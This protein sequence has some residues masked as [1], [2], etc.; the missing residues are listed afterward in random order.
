MIW[1]TWRQHRGQILTT[2][3]FLLALGALLL[4]SGLQ[5]YRISESLRNC[6]DSAGDLCTVFVT[7]IDGLYQGVYQVYGWM[8]LLIPALIGAFWGAPLL[9]R[10]FERG[11]D[12]LVWTQSVP[13][14][15]WIVVKLA[16]LG[17]LVTLG[18]LALSAMASA[19]RVAFDA[20][21]GESWFGNIGVFN[22]V[23]VAPPAW[24]LFAFALGTASGALLR[25]VLP[26]M[27]VTAAGV[28]LTM[29]GLFSLSDFY[30][31]PVRKVVAERRDAFVQDIRLVGVTWVAPSGEETADPPLRVCQVGPDVRPDG[32]RYVQEQCLFENGYR[33]AVYHHP[34]SRF[35]RFQWT[36]AGILLVGSALLFGLTVARTVRRTR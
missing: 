16:V 32:E 34:P 2:A 9:A 36:E 8:P 26:A 14:K 4:V 5:G 25:K 22:M 28:A 30:A 27:A 33:L 18:G 10:E 6:S 7:E 11:T 1:L 3:G 24:W 23:G 13:P 31:E 20:V 35:W 15:R 21:L 12:Q 19:W 29:F 17:G